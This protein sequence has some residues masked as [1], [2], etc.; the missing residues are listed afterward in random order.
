M[1]DPDDYYRDESG[2]AYHRSVHQDQLESQAIFLAKAS[3][4]RH[5]YFR[6]LSPD[7]RVF[8]FGVGLGT[9]LAHLPNA[10]KHGFDV[11]GFAATR[12]QATGVHVFTSMEAVPLS[13]Y[14]LV[15]CRHVLEHVTHPV[16]VL[17]DLKRLLATGGML[18]LVLPVERPSQSRTL[19]TPDVNRHLYSWDLQL[20]VNLLQH[21]GMRATHHRYYW[22]SM[23]TRLRWVRRVLGM[24]S[25]SGAVTIA[26]GLRRQRE[27]AVWAMA[28][29]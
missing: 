13:Q 15:L 1:P 6:D 21:V 8:E 22:Y 7:A 27:L 10:V 23:Q 2:E 25:Y 17:L 9:N 20:T 5:R 24:A 18:L 26:G 12:A 3:L 11:S 16:D 14:D 28:D 4:A 19:P 29:D